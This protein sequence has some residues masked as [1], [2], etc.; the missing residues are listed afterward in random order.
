[1]YLITTSS[2]FQPFH[3]P[4]LIFELKTVMKRLYLNEKL[5]TYLLRKE[6]VLNKIDSVIKR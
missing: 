2:I 3:D 6:F 5:L 4:L 1:M